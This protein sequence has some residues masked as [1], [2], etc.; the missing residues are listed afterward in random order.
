MAESIYTKGNAHLKGRNILGCIYGNDRFPIGGYESFNTTEKSSNVELEMFF[1]HHTENRNATDVLRCVLGENIML[2]HDGSR[3]GSDPYGS[4][5]RVR[6]RTMVLSGEYCPR[7]YSFMITRR[8][9][10]RGLICA[11]YGTGTVQVRS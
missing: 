7:R 10:D 4:V 5:V 2:A 9:N 6:I 3:D 1:N 8:V 11:M